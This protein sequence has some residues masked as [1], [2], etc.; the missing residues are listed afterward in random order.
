[1]VFWNGDAVCCISL[2]TRCDEITGQEVFEMQCQEIARCPRA[3]VEGGSDH[4]QISIN[5]KYHKLLLE[6][7][8]ERGIKNKSEL[9]EEL[10]V[11][12][13]YTD[14]K[15]KDCMKNCPMYEDESNGQKS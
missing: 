3:Y 13:I 9:I 4:L 6:R 15:T 7:M 10:L 11:C 1:M 8:E 5:P 2:N 14:P 12:W